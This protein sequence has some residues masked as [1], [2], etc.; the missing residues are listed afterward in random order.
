[1]TVY[2]ALNITNHELYHKWGFETDSVFF[3]GEAGIEFNVNGTKDE[4][5]DVLD[6][7]SKYGKIES[8]HITE[9]K[10]KWGNPYCVV[11]IFDVSEVEC[12]LK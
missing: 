1:M 3:Y 8:F 4:L 11:E 2:P 6:A 12:I 10:P 7:I 5:S 9:K